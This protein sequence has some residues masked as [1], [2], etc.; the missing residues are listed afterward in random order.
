MCCV[1]FDVIGQTMKRTTSNID[2]IRRR[3]SLAG[4][5][6]VL[7]CLVLLAFAPIAAA[8]TLPYEQGLATFRTSMTGP[9]PFMISLVGIIGCGAMLIFG[10][11]ISGFLRT[12]VFIVLVVSVIVEASS[13]V[14]LFGGSWT[15]DAQP[16]TFVLS[17]PSAAA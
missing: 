2:Q 15:G 10:G 14:E 3:R 7:V 17:P 12:M 9:V 16:A 8:Q 11:E 1:I 5:T 13:I 6:T 4:A